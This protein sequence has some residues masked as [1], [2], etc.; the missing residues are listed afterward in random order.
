MKQSTTQ[1]DW[2]TYKKEIKE[3]LQNFFDLKKSSFI[4]ENQ[5]YKI[6]SLSD[7]ELLSSTNL[8]K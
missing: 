4:S 7:E 6:N 3:N 5:M 1:K 2:I 8:W